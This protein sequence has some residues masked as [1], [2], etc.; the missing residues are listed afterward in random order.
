MRSH[1]APATSPIRIFIIPS[2]KIV[3][4]QF[5]DIMVM[6]TLP[7]KTP[8]QLIRAAAD[9]VSSL[10]CSSIRFVPGVRTQL[11]QMVAGKSARINI[12]GR[13]PPKHDMSRPLAEIAAKQVKMIDLRWYFL[14]TFM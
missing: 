5:R 1:S 11:P 4:L 2:T 9:P 7:M 14:D 6:P 12:Q 13:K 3:S 8:K 10:C